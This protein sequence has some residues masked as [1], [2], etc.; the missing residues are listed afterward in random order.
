VVRIPVV[1]G[2]EHAQPFLLLDS[3]RLNGEPVPWAHGSGDEAIVDDRKRVRPFAEGATITVDLPTLAPGTHMLSFT[4]VCGHVAFIEPGLLE[5]FA[6]DPK[7]RTE[8]ASWGIPAFGEMRT[9]EIP[10]VVEPLTES[11]GGTPDD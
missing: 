10:C 3:V 2:S 5:R 1:L 6:A 9:F 11:A 8:P 7:R 4:A